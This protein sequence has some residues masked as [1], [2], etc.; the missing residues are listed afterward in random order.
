VSRCNL[1]VDGVRA[2]GFKGAFLYHERHRGAGLAIPEAGFIMLD[3]LTDLLVV[4]EN[5]TAAIAGHKPE[6]LL[7]TPPLHD[8]L[9]SHKILSRGEADRGGNPRSVASICSGRHCH[10]VYR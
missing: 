7:R 1:N 5:V 9:L 10:E 3:F 8:S 2:A 4:R 6:T